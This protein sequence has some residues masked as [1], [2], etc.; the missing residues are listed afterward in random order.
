M[1]T[2]TFDVDAFREAFPQF[3]SETDFPD[4]TLQG[5]WDTAICIISDQNYGRMTGACRSRALNLLT[6]HLA[7]LAIQINEGKTP[8]LVS[9]STVGQVSVTLTPPPEANQFKWW[10]SLTGYGQQLLAILSAQG[11]GGFYVGGLAESR[12]FRKIGGFF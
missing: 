1:T 10:L 4:A 5:Y 11:I 3:A 7:T 6:A 9:G 12:G 8:G 2:I